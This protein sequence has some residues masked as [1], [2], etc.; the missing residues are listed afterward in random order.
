MSFIPEDVN[1]LPCNT[2]KCGNCGVFR[3]INDDGVVERCPQCG[4]DDYPVWGWYPDEIER[5]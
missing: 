4:D 2:E 3:D 5:E 1:Q